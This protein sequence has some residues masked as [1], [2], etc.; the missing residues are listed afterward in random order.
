MS[1]QQSIAR[2]KELVYRVHPSRLEGEVTVSGAKNSALR[3]LAASILTDEKVQL[4]NYPEQ[5]RDA[6][7][8]VEMLRVLGKTCTVSRDEIQISQDKAL[9]TKLDWQERSI[10]NTLLILGA[11]LAK[12]GEG[13]VPLPGGCKLGERK[14]DLH[15]LVFE[16]L[17]AEVWEDDTFLYART[18]KRLKGND[19]HLSLRSTGATENAIICGSLAEG[20]T[21]VW[22]P[23]VRPE[24]LDLIRMLRQMG[25][26]ITVYGQEK[27]EIRGV[28]K[29]NG[30][31]YR[32]LP[33][34]MEALTWLV[35]ATV[36]GGDLTIRDFPFK[37][38]EV[39]LVFLRE[40]GAQFYSN[41]E[42]LV[43]R[44]GTPFP[45]EI[46]TG[47]YPGIN[48]DMQPILA[49][50]GA[51]AQGE[52]RIID[53]RFPGRY[54]YAEELEKM[55]VAYE[56]K[57]NMLIIHGGN[58]LKGAEVRASDLR[59]GAA[60]LIAGFVATGET[61]IRDAW[62]I[63]RGYNRMTEKLKAIGGNVRF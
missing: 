15:V 8:H 30:V 57:G 49:L 1:I 44:G 37:D 21:T 52:T 31:N 59:A 54:A 3:L 4:T 40:S 7:I 48:S 32:V 2:E 34:N 25:A 45:L 12:Y 36:T 53:L 29:L 51:M 50:Y 10:R 43:V 58:A 35:A 16:S 63:E 13:A 39:P 23:H 18:N 6:V 22:N 38:L 46:S 20:T 14:Y 28:E 26:G 55:G 33:D 42:A 47:P 27:I 60:L 62:Q 24:I 19:I 56:T 9:A 11:L 17:G 61:I 41:E 5:L